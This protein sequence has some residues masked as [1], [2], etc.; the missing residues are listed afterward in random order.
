MAEEG[1][2]STPLLT[3]LPLGR[4]KCQWGM[5]ESQD[6][7]LRER[8]GVTAEKGEKNSYFFEDM[9]FFFLLF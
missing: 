2:D 4:L 9:F 8:G 5:A 6:G 3:L 1:Q 7:R